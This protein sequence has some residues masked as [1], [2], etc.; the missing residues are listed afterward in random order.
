MLFTLLFFFW[1]TGQPLLPQNQPVQLEKPVE[2]P[3]QS[4][5]HTMDTVFDLQPDG[6]PSSTPPTSSA[7]PPPTSDFPAELTASPI[8]PPTFTAPPPPIALSS[9]S[10]TQ[11]NPLLKASAA[12][13]VQST[14]AFSRP[15]ISNVTNEELPTTTANLPP[16]ATITTATVTESSSGPS[17]AVTSTSSYQENVSVPAP[18]VTT[19]S[20]EVQDVDDRSRYEH[21]RGSEG[22]EYDF[23]QRDPR[24]RRY[25]YGGHWDY[26]NGRSYQYDRRDRYHRPHSRTAYEYD[27][28]YDP[29][30]KEY[31]RHYDP[32][33]PYY[34]PPHHYTSYY[35]E[36]DY[37]SRRQR[38]D[39]RYQRS[40]HD[41]Y[42]YY[43]DPYYQGRYPQDKPDYGYYSYH[44]SYYNDYRYHGQSYHHPPRSASIQDPPPSAHH[45]PVG[46]YMEPQSLEASAIYGQQDQTDTSYS[47]YQ[48]EGE[49]PYESTHIEQP[50]VEGYPSEYG[51]T[52]SEH[53]AGEGA[54]REGEYSQ[55]PDVSHRYAV[56]GYG[57]EQ[58]WTPPSMQGKRL[59]SD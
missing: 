36:R 44:D 41:Y 58:E 33:D 19:S 23:Y 3:L 24:D 14:S 1:T 8:Q 11:F 50:P 59:L 4:I 55:P 35:D 32:H 26:Y 12:P 30:R 9:V 21:R 20:S 47:Y 39:P 13:V 48:Y 56:G 22:P 54:E 6:E 10:Q 18:L 17:T 40:D 37:Y 45:Q 43:D 5:S 28:R 38:Y 25:D 53:Y 27:P 15:S 31:D 51:Y 52:H 57:E 42:Q 7:T 2:Q 34:R 46:E 16:A 49:M 29:P